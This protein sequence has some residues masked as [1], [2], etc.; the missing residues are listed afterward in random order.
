MSGLK[1]GLSGYIPVRNGIRLDYCWTEAA[2]SLLPVCDELILCDSDSTDGTREF[3]EDWA[4]RDPKIRVINRPWP[5]LP[6]FAEW[7]ADKM[8]P[9]S[10]ALMLVK[11][12]NWIRQHC[13]YDMQIT[14]D[15]DEVLDDRCHQKIRRAVELREARWFRRLNFWQDA[16]HL[17]PDGHVC[18]SNVVRLGPTELEMVSDEPRPGGEPPIRER[19]V[20]ESG[21]TFFHYGFLRK[22]DA[23]FEKAKVMH[24][25]LHS[26]YDPRLLEAELSGKPWFELSRWPDNI[27]LATYHDGYHPGCAR[28]WLRAR[29]YQLP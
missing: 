2:E 21:L 11:W 24:L 1:R 7:K 18:G 4:K 27:P 9:P 3:M 16:Q 17:V 26:S 6:T 20:M 19:A 15:A 23:F 10:D 22:Q 8:R 13:R 28:A 14:T 5:E 12:L 25:A 29:G